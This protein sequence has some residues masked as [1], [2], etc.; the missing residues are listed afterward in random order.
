MSETCPK[1]G[2]EYDSLLDMWSHKNNSR[3]CLTAQLAAKTAECEKLKEELAALSK[4]QVIRT[5]DWG[6]Q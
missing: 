6:D 1:C 2:H 4:P 3:I 5:D